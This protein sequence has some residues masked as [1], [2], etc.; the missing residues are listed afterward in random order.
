MKEGILLLFPVLG[1]IPLVAMLLW[2]KK[3]QGKGLM[4]LLSILIFAAIVWAC[5]HYQ[6]RIYDNGGLGLY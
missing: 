3:K 4:I 5:V 2:I 1:L 6:I